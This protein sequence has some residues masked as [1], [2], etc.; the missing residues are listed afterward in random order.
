MRRYSLR[1]SRAARSRVSGFV[2]WHEAADFRGAS[3]R[4]LSE[5]SGHTQS[6]GFDLLVATD[7]SCVKTRWSMWLPN[8]QMAPTPMQ[9]FSLVERLQDARA[10]GEIGE[11][12]DIE[13]AA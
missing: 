8:S 4:S 13:R 12:V 6:C 1:P 3:I 11:T 2:L 9:P 7:P 10:A 5:R